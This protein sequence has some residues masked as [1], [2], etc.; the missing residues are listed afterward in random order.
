MTKLTGNKNSVP[1]EF[2]VVAVEGDLLLSTASTDYNEVASNAER[3]NGK[4]V[5]Y[6]NK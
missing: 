2:W 4:V 3:I 5:K 1:S 6:G